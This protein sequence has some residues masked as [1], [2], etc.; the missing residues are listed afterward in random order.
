MNNL[1]SISG[2]ETVM[3]RYVF[4]I[5]VAPLTTD[6]V[7]QMGVLDRKYFPPEYARSNSGLESEFHDP[8][9]MG[10]GLFD[11][12]GELT[13]HIS[14]FELGTDEIEDVEDGLTVVA[15]GDKFKSM[16][17]EQMKDWVKEEMKNN[18]I[19]YVSNFVID[20]THRLHIIKLIQRLGEVGLEKGYKYVAFHA[21]S[22][23]YN[24]LFKGVKGFAVRGVLNRALT[25]KLIPQINVKTQDEED[26]YVFEVAKK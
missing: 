15:L 19:F 16:S 18:K 9:F 3:L 21:L 6:H 23:T 17:E 5:S 26:L 20:P 8:G 13:G 1:L 4:A 12:K 2:Y 7:P 14:G 22:D 11:D 10:H 24:M 25:F